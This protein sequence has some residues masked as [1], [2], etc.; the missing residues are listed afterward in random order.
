VKGKKTTSSDRQ[1]PR[2]EAVLSPNRGVHLIAQNGVVELPPD[3]IAVEAIGQKAIGLLTLPQCWTPPF[4]IVLDQVLT[5]ELPIGR[6]AHMLHEAAVRSGVSQDRV[7]VRSN[8]IEEG[9]SQRGALES[10]ACSWD[11]VE[12]VLRDLR[13]KAVQI[14]DSVTHWIIQEAVPVHEKGQLSNERRVRYDGRDWAIEFEALHGRN[15][16]QSSIAVRKWRNGQVVTETPLSCDSDLKISLALGQVARW[17]VQDSRRFLFEWIWD[18]TTVHIVQMDVATTSGG[19]NPRDLLPSEIVSTEVRPLKCFAVAGVEQRK[20]FRKLTNAVLYEECGYSMPPFYV[21]DDQGAIA[22]ILRDGE[23]STDLLSDLEVLTSRPLVLRTDGG[24]LPR[25]KQEMLPRSEELRSPKAAADWLC[26]AFRS[27]ISRLGLNGSSIALIGHHFIPSVASAWAGAEPGKRWVRIE[28]LWGI[29]ESLYWHSHDTF[30]VDAEN[31]KLDSPL[32]QTCDYPIKRRER[33]K[34]TFIAPDVNGAWIHHQT[35]QPFDWSPTINSAQSLCEIAHTTRRICERLQQPVEVMWFVD[36]HS[37]A[38]THNVLPW[39]HSIPE[40]TDVPVSAPRKKIKSSQERYIRDQGDWKALQKAI[41]TAVK[42]ERVIVEPHDPELVRNPTFAEELGSLAKS[43]GIVVVL[44]GGILSHAYHALRRAGASVECIDLFGTTEDRAEY[45]KLV[46]DKVPAQI[47]DRGEH[48]EIVR[49]EGDALII[50]LRRKLV[51]EAIEALDA[52][53]GADLVGELAD[54]QEVI[55]AIAKAIQVSGHQLEDERLRK[56]KKRG[57]F[58]EGYMLL[59]TMSPHSIARASSSGQLLVLPKNSSPR[60]ITD[61]N[62]VPQK[63]VYKRPDHRTLVDST[64]ELLVVE[65]ELN[66]LGTVVES[67]NF[68]LPADLDSRRYT[69]SIELSRKGGELRAAVRLQARKRQNES[70]AQMPLDFGGS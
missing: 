18:G 57:G 12:A 29:P 16:Y 11:Q 32:G 67:I 44:A 56:L 15:T 39:Y 68:E 4:F 60:A 10:K 53:S 23:I 43:N 21:L 69:S 30:E 6:F 28:A 8:G 62:N 52:P 64:E 50:A 20:R 41:G 5:E 35:K 42:V 46:R 51:E 66:R 9:L 31:A 26:G 25:E 45:N 3:P 17:A 63:A 55:K 48:F 61:P 38:T 37:G 27:E 13:A 33:F 49:L 47:A 1:R 54:T 36:T 58:E 14:S 34:G 19:E 24:D 7:M 22:T 70:D 65:T 2:K 59:T 40:N